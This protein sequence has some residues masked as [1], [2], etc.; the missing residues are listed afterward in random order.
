ML[1]P[2]NYQDWSDADDDQFSSLF[3]NQLENN[4]SG[5]QGLDENHE[6]KCRFAFMRLLQCFILKFIFQ[7]F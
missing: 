1:F 3:V 2:N 7:F 6:D 5:F 4:T